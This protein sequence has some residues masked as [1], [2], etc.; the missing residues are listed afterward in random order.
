MKLELLVFERLKLEH[1]LKLI[2]FKTKVIKV[3]L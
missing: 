2:D 3:Y 1:L